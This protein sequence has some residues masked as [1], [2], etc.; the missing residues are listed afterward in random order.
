[1]LIALKALMSRNVLVVAAV[2]G[3][4]A[5]ARIE[6]GIAIKKHDARV[7][8]EAVRGA[9]QQVGEASREKVKVAKAAQRRVDPA[10]SGGVLAKRYCADCDG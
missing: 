7:A 1:M 4:I 10:R 2:I 9:L 6:A 5:W 3:L 8:G